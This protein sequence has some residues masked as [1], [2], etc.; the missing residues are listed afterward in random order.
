MM[1]KVKEWCDE[2]TNEVIADTIRAEV[3][4]GQVGVIT[5]GRNIMGP[6]MIAWN[7]RV[8]RIVNQQEGRWQ[9]NEFGERIAI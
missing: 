9:K 1:R 4:R 2:G 5:H 3:M 6:Q 8:N 7:D